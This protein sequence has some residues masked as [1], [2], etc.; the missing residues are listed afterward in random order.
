[1]PVSLT[2][3]KGV[4][5]HFVLDIS[6]KTWEK[7]PKGHFHFTYYKKRWDS[8]GRKTGSLAERTLFKKLKAVL[9]ETLAWPINHCFG[10][11]KINW[12]PHELSTL[13][14]HKQQDEF[15]I[16]IKRAWGG[17][18]AVSLG[19]IWG[20]GGSL[21]AGPMYSGSFPLGLCLALA[22]TRVASCTHV[23]STG[24]HASYRVHCEK[25]CCA[26]RPE[27]WR[28]TRT[29]RSSDGVSSCWRS[30]PF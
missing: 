1:M 30:N 10:A 9:N 18:W 19:A 16:K 24:A 25:G 14:R 13:S 21:A 5:F 8:T 22:H 3:K 23:S 27:P 11:K 12:F 17:P 6:C 29:R 20:K 2:T 15:Q 28:G 26:W 4:L 7:T